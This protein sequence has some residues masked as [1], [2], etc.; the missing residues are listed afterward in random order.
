MVQAII[1]PTPNC[2]STGFSTLDITC[3]K[4]VQASHFYSLQYLDHT[5]SL[6]QIVV[7]QLL[8]LLLQITASS[9]SL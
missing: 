9:P 2:L 5:Y 8:V 1:T 3:D 4:I 6:V 7:T